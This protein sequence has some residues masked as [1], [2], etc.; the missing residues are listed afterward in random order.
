MSVSTSFCP[1]SPLMRVRCRLSVDSEGLRVPGWHFSFVQ[2]VEHGSWL[3]H[4]VSVE[5]KVWMLWACS[6][7]VDVWSSPLLLPVNQCLNF[8]SCW[9]FNSIPY[10]HPCSF[11]SFDRV[12][13]CRPGWHLTH[14][15]L[16]TSASQVLALKACVTVPGL[17]PLFLLRKSSHIKLLALSLV[18]LSRTRLWW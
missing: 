8:S 13:Q 2:G 16:P 10:P 5:M 15:D 12:S 3:Q 6:A 9:I 17:L 1:S 11:L 14:W 4:I 18:Q 7:F